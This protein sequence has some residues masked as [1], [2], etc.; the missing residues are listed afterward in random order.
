MPAPIVARWW[1]FVVWVRRVASSLCSEAS[2]LISS[3]VSSCGNRTERISSVT[4][5]TA[6]SWERLSTPNPTTSAI[7]VPMAAASL[8]R[9]LIRSSACGIDGPGYCR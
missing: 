1:K 4:L 9:M 7:A 5:L 3:T 2:R 6:C 8:V